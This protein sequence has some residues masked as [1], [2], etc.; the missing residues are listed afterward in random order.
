M[1]F[2]AVQVTYAE[3]TCK[4]PELP[5]L[6]MISDFSPIKTCLMTK[7]PTIELSWFND[8]IPSLN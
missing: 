1:V 6:Q 5:E 8:M 7:W 4:V 3:G 2:V